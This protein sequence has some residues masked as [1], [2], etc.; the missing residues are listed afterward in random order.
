MKI[1][2]AKEVHSIEETKE[3]IDKI[4]VYIK[5]G[6]TL[7]LIGE[8]GA[9]KTTVTRY[10]V[11]KLGSK[12]PVSSPTY[13]LQ[14]EYSIEGG[15]IEHWDLYRLNCQ[16]MELSEPVS[17]ENIRIIEWADKFDDVLKSLDYSLKI[18]VLSENEREFAFIQT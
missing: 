10:L 4:L 5:P 3:F 18:D 14:H 6:V 2:E 9:G 7:G 11:E 13:I 15:V 1:I 8:L 17:P 12:D 16:A